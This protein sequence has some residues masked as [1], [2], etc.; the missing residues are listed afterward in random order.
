MSE[1]S[2]TPFPVLSLHIHDPF[3]VFTHLISLSPESLAS[4][5]QIVPHYWCPGMRGDHQANLARILVQR[6]Y[7]SVVLLDELA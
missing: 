1:I 7:S 3:C 4:C 6:A 5:L 2:L